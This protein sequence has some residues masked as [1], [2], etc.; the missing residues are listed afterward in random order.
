MGLFSKPEYLEIVLPYLYDDCP[1]DVETCVI[2]IEAYGRIMDDY[3]YCYASFEVRVNHYDELSKLLITAEQNLVKVIVK[4]KNGIAKDFKIDLQDLA[5][6]FH[7]KRFEKIELLAW[8][9]NDKSAI[10]QN[11]QT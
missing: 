4:V 8:G 9:F 6:R 2:S 7:D 1:E 10:K 11:V 5:E 3:H